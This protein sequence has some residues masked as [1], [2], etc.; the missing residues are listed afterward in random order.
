MVSLLPRMPCVWSQILG[1]GAVT[2]RRNNKLTGEG[3]CFWP[4]RK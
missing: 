3:S 1:E 4:I 2:V